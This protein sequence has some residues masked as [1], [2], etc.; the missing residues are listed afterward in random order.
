MAADTTKPRRALWGVPAGRASSAAEASTKGVVSYFSKGFGEVAT[1]VKGFLRKHHL[2]DK[3]ATK[4]APLWDLSGVAAGSFCNPADGKGACSVDHSAVASGMSA[5]YDKQYDLRDELATS[6]LE[7][8]AL[9]SLE[10]EVGYRH[11][12]LFATKARAA[13]DGQGRGAAAAQPLVVAPAVAAVGG[14]IVPPLTDA[15]VT[16]IPGGEGSNSA[17]ATLASG[18]GAGGAPPSL[19]HDFSPRGR[20]GVGR[21]R[22]SA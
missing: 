3:W 20:G 12:A 4:N 10:G 6:V 1:D 8:E 18:G 11:V 16:T 13:L 7:K 21:R 15:G 19:A 5:L 9:S 14:S 2:A 17:V 22:L